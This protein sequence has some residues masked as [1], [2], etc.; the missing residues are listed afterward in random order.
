MAKLTIDCSASP[1]TS[2]R[3]TIL[4]S[5]RNSSWIGERKLRSPTTSSLAWLCFSV[6]WAYFA[7]R[8]QRATTMKPRSV[9]L[10]LRR[11]TQLL[12]AGF[13]CVPTH[14]RCHTLDQRHR[15]EEPHRRRGREAQEDQGSRLLRA[16]TVSAHLPEAVGHQALQRCRSRASQS[17]RKV[18]F[19]CVQKVAPDVGRGASR[20]PLANTG[21]PKT[22]SFA[23]KKLCRGGNDNV[24]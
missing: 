2:W 5:G 21:S 18:L 3:I 1:S 13:P 24:G 19:A 17:A 6:A 11:W 23:T 12:V 15:K 4:T 14:P 22:L 16:G 8:L 7:R 10:E 20:V 9:E